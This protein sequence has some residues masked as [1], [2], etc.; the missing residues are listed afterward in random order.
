MLVYSYILVK[1][2]IRLVDGQIYIDYAGT[3][4]D[5]VPLV[6]MLC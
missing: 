5:L 1:D 3:L 4:M 6:I 2:T